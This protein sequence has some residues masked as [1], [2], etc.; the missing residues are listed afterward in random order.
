[1]INQKQSYQEQSEAIQIIINRL[2]KELELV[3]NFINQ[4]V[5]IEYW[6]GVKYGIAFALAGFSATGIS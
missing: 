2:K 1:M 3:E 6:Q 4:D 5:N